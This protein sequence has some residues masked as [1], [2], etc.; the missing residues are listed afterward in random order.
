MEVALFKADPVLKAVEGRAAPGE[1]IFV[2]PSSPEYYFLTATTNPTR[3][4]GLGYNYNS[5]SDFQGVVR[6]LDEHHVRYVLWD[7]G[8]DEKS[9]QT[10]FSRR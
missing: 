6:I 7:T 5:S 2:Y 4:S 8:L 9:A 10:L 1:E 3:Y